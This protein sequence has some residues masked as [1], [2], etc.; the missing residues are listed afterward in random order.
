MKKI[1]AIFVSILM[2]M[3]LLS[4]CGKGS[5]SSGKKKGDPNT[6][7]VANDSDAISLDPMGTNDNASSKVLV[8]I[9]E[10]LFDLNAEGKEVPLLAES[11][12]KKSDTEYVIHLKKG[13]KFHNGDEMKAS[14]VVFSLKRAC[15]APNVKHLF[16]TIKKDSIKADDDYTVS[17]SLEFPFP[18]I[19]ASFMHPGGSILSEKAV[20]AAGDNYGSSTDTVV[21]TGPFK[22][23]EWSKANAIKLSRFED[24]HAEKSAMAKLEFKIIPEPTNRL[25]E[26]QTGGADIAY[27]LQPMDVE[28]VEKDENLTMFKSLDYGTTYLGFNTQKAPFDNPKVREAIAYAIDIP[29]LIPKVWLGLGKPASNAMPPTLKY[30]IGDSTKP[31]ERDVEKAKALL[32]EAGYENGFD[33]TISTNERKQRV[34]MATIIKEQLKDVGINVTINVMEWSA[35]N[36]LLK[37]GQQDMFEIAWIA[38]TPD[39]DSFL[40]PCF[41]SS[42]KGEGG[43]YCFLEDPQMDK[44]L[45]DARKEQD[46]TKRGEIYKEVQQYILDNQIWIPQYWSELTVGASK[47]VEGFEQNPFGFYKLNK[48]KV[49][50]GE[51]K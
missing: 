31:K 14:D 3:S 45:E 43:N 16:N 18:G 44:L 6:L 37:N 27:E 36:D 15:E 11:Y 33:T 34:D 29:G 39:P 4:G 17:F 19:I 2:V 41:H 12:D 20:K 10:G 49:N 23:D 25:V 21:G 8:Q 30:S 48:V 1:L 24:Y 22:L 40:F 9:Y 50:V 51:A 47:N 46:E 26:L 32:K 7:V 42:A 5:K 28:K 13:V 35:Y 38:D